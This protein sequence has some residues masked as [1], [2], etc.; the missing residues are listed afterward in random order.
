MC[1]TLGD[2]DKINLCYLDQYHY[3]GLFNQTQLARIKSSTTVYTSVAKRAEKGK[4]A[5]P[6]QVTPAGETAWDTL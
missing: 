1:F 5:A 3:Q 6:C 4:D 2:N